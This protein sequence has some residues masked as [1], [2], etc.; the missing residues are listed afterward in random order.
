[1]EISCYYCC[2]NILKTRIHKT[3]ISNT[4]SLKKGDSVCSVDFD[5]SLEGLVG[6]G[7]IGIPVRVALK[8][9]RSYRQDVVCSH[10]ETEHNLD[11]EILVSSTSN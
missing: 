9:R 11:F 1:M 5:M 10:Y 8:L 7:E 6:S 4:S 2:H 3:N